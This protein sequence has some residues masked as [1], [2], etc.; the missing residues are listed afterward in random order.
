M[1]TL[2]LR[3]YIKP[4]GSDSQVSELFDLVGAAKMFNL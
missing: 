2:P 1:I 3:A 4:T